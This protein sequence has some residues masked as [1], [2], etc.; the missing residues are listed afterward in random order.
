MCNDLDAQVMRMVL[1]AN[2]G[3]HIYKTIA[4]WIYFQ[5]YHCTGK[6]E[7]KDIETTS[8]IPAKISKDFF[9]ITPRALFAKKASD[10]VSE[11]C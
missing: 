5:T 8:L 6:L 2:M 4:E 7:T 9:T 3:N 11:A 1:K 10:A